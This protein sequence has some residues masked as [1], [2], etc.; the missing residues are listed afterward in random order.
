MYPSTSAEAIDSSIRMAMNSQGVGSVELAKACG[1][2]QGQVDGIISALAQ[3][4]MDMSVASLIAISEALDLKPVLATSHLAEDFFDMVRDVL[5]PV[6]SVFDETFIPY[7][8]PAG[9]DM[10]P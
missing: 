4:R 5:D 6:E 3:G 7:V 9:G 2:D 8:P 10:K 1:M